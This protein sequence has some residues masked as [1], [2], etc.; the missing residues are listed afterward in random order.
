MRRSVGRKASNCQVHPAA[1]HRRHERSAD[2]LLARSSDGGYARDGGRRDHPRHVEC[3]G[4][5]GCSHVS[6]SHDPIN[7]SVFYRVAV[8]AM[9]NVD[10]HFRVH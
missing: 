7:D 6:E 3:T 2:A 9:D 4:E 1:G 8:A 10:K 5:D